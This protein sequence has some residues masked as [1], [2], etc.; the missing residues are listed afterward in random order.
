MR[1][2]PAPARG[3]WVIARYTFRECVRRRVTV[4]VPLLSAA[5][6]ALYGLGVHFAFEAAHGT[7]QAQGGLVDTQSLV[8]ATLVGL[9]MFATLFLGAVFAVFLTFNTVRGDAE[10]G[11]LQTLVVRPIGRPA[12][13]AGRFVG[14]SILCGGYVFVMY[15][16]AVLITGRLGGWWPHPLLLPGATLVG[17]VLIVAA[18]SVLV[19]VFLTA[20]PSG[21]V[22]L[23][24]YLAGLLGG[25]LGQIGDALSLSKLQTTGRYI[26]FVIPFEALYQQGLNSLTSGVTGLAR[27]I[28]Q[29]GPFG[30]A[31]DFGGWLWPYCL[32]YLVVVAVLAGWTFAR[33]DL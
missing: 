5:F 20:I 11:S 26:A 19:S 1:R 33:R 28:V 10:S 3:A 13:L 12:L 27:V 7:T 16:A 22:V 18:L 29:L 8:G 17:A 14:A 6:L 25:L 23:M 4:V 21:I 2:S 24:L 32:G 15:L 9:A 30:G 31:Q